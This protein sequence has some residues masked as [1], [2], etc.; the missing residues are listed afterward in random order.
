MI[1]FSLTDTNTYFFI[2]EIF[3]AADEELSSTKTNMFTYILYKTSIYANFSEI[4]CIYYF[5]KNVNF[6]EKLTNLLQQQL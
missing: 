4:N 5:S 1:F 6:Q 3:L 2:G